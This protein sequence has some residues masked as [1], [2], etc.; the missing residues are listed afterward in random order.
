MHVKGRQVIPLMVAAR[1]MVLAVLMVLVS[2]VSAGAADIKFLGVVV[3]PAPGKYL[4]EKDVNVRSGP[5]TDSK[6]VDGLSAG[7]VV[8]V[9]GRAPGTVWLAVIKDGAP[10]GFVYGTVLSPIVDGSIDKDVTGEVQISPG[11]RCGFRVRYIGRTEGEDQAVLAA[12]YDA[13]IVCERGGMRIRFP[14]QMFMTEVP[15]DG[16]NKRRVFQI[17]VDLLDTLH[18][19][20]DVFSTIMLFD[21][22]QGEVRFDGV[23]EDSY[24][25]ADVLIG[26]LPATDVPRALA[27]AVELALTHWSA[28][29]WDAIF[30]KAG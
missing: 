8:Q 21:L 18:D 19:L 15:F 28:Q 30:K 10:L 4:V 27:S 6:R 13:T 23:S 25:K 3:T 29:A 11:H 14:A 12:D 2:G 22:D 17:N 1:R 16:S 9:V 7:Q 24:G 5:R 20:D 26:A